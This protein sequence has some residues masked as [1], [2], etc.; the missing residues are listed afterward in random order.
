MDYPKALRMFNTAWDEKS[1]LRSNVLLQVA[2]PKEFFETISVHA[3]N[4]NVDPILVLSLIRQESSFNVRAIS[5]SGALG[6]MQIIPPTAQEIGQ[7]LKIQNLEIPQT[8]FN[9]EV[10]IRMGTYYI[11]KMIRDFNNN[12]PFGLAAYNVGPTRL[13][14]WMDSAGVKPQSTSSSE[15]EVWIDMLPWAETRFYVKAILRNFIIYQ[16]VD[17]KPIQVKDPV[18]PVSEG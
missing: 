6:L 14:R 16:L 1:E 13:K 15:Y 12:V 3:K 4:F 8:L 11:S 5:S 7:A 17:L 2:F 10:N 9:P 18:W